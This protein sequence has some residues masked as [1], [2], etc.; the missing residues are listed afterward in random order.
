MRV[1][2]GKAA[3]NALSRRDFARFNPSILGLGDIMREGASVEALAAVYDLEGF[4]AF[5]GQD[6]SHLVVH[7]FLEMFLAWLFRQ[8][9]QSFTR[10]EEGDQVLIWGRLPF[11]AKFLGDGVLFLW[12]TNPPDDRIRGDK[13]IGNIALG[14]LKTCLAYKA[15][16]LPTARKRFAAPP[17]RLRC[18]VARGRVLPIGDGQD[19]VGPCINLASRLQKLSPLSFA[20]SAKGV[21]IEKAMDPGDACHFVPKRIKVRGLKVEQLVYV[22]TDE[23]KKLT[24]AERDEF[25]EP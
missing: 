23:V 16:F 5:C 22:L 21:N 20:I 19:F 15:E 4:T 17:Q 10:K 12:D 24:A 14:L 9:A 1:V 18:G 6:D 2:E 3:F 13:A 8:T 7:E 25:Q 11:F